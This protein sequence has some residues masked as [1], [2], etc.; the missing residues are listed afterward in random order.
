MKSSH[1]SQLGPTELSEPYRTFL[2]SNQ[3]CTVLFHKNNKKCQLLRHQEQNKHSV[4]DIS[5]HKTYIKV[6]SN[7]S[8]IHKCLLDCAPE[9]L[10]K[11]PFSLKG[12]MAIKTDCAVFT[13]SDVTPEH[14]RPLGSVCVYFSQ[15][16]LFKVS[17]LLL[18]LNFEV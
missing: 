13:V 5:S 16:P 8:Y 18:L 9:L 4:I 11:V 15:L 2:I 12:V 17:V 14:Q 3:R 1:G 10:R 7:I 6:Y